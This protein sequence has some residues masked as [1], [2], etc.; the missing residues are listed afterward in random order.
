MCGA[1]GCTRIKNSRS[2]AA[3]LVSHVIASFTNTIIAEMAVLK[4]S[5]S[6][7]SVTFLMQVCS[8]LS[9]SFVASASLMAAFKRISAKN[10][11][12]LPAFAVVIA[13]S[14]SV[15]LFSSTNKRQTRPRKR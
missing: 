12:P 9:C 4:R 10:S 8:A 2:T 7:S 5:P 11:S 6:R 1:K 13:C 15:S 3:G 14:N